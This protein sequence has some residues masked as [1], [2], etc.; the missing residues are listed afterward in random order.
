[1]SSP[2]VDGDV[3]D[4]FGAVRDEFVRNFTE[5][6][7]IGAACA[8]YVE[9]RKVVD[10]WGGDR[11]AI[12][13]DLWQ[14]DTMVLVFSTT[15]GMAASAMA[16]AH[17]RGLF[18]LDDPASKHWPEFAQNGTSELT[19][20]QFLSHQAGLCALDARLT[21]ELFG[22]GD[23][24]CAHVVDLLDRKAATV[25]RQIAELRRPQRELDQLRRR[26]TEVDPATCAPGNVCEVL[27]P[28]IP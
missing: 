16:V 17:S 1:M 23:A 18:Q 15:K 26:A 12:S 5:R 10:L 20:R 27:H 24:P 11:D 4:G 9:D 2:G 22:D 6:R 21:P 28:L 7:E 19:I 25:A 13:G 8:V 3:D 14:R